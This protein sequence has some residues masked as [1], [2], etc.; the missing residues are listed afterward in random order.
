MKIEDG[1]I[2]TFL[3][4]LFA[5]PYDE[6]NSKYLTKEVIME[7][8]IFRKFEDDFFLSVFIC[9]NAVFEQ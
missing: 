4:I 7:K 2:V 9:F 1:G 3:L 8:C 6:T 5:E